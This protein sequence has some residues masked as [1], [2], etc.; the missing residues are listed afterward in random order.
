LQIRIAVPADWQAII[1]IYNQAVAEPFCTA[2]TEPATL[3]SRSGW[4][5]QHESG[6]YP[7]FVAEQQGAV[8]GWCSLSPWRA[9]RKALEK[10]AEISYYIDRSQRGLG[11]GSLLLQHALDRCPSLGIG[12]LLAIL[13]ERNAAS[14]RLL[15]KFA[16]IRWGHLPEVAEFGSQLCGQ[17]IY[18]RKV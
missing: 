3:E 1:D 4:L 7:I 17:Y 16:F 13:L 8:V 6:Q 18:G 14:I 2:D 9:G 5:A 10:T 11:L 15:E 12:N